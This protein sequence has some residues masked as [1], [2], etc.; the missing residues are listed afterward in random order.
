MLPEDSCFNNSDRALKCHAIVT[1]L[2]SLMLVT[3]LSSFML[4]TESS[5]ASR[6][7]DRALKCHAT[8]TESSQV[9]HYRDKVSHYLNRALKCHT[10]LTELSCVILQGQS[11]QVSCYSDRALKSLYSDRALKYHTTWQSSQVS[12]Y[13]GRALKSHAK[14]TELSIL[15]LQWRSSQV[16]YCSNANLKISCTDHA[17]AYCLMTKS[18]TKNFYLIWSSK[19]TSF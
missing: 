17:H 3:E 14:V 18:I 12:R 16:S 11:S 5:Q 9:S 10:I 4:V 6:Y 15:M 19:L 7:H 13:S 8:M 1:E 2:S